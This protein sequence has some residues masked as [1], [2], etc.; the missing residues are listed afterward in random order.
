LHKLLDHR[1]PAQHAEQFAIGT[2]NGPRARRLPQSGGLRIGGCSKQRLLVSK[3]RVLQKY[4]ASVTAIPLVHV[5]RTGAHQDDSFLLEAKGLRATQDASHEL[6]GG[7]Q[8]KT[9]R[10]FG[11]AGW[12]LQPEPAQMR[13]HGFRGSA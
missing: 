13:I 6:I 7:P 3:S 12:I 11:L 2:W 1:R 8:S 5:K 10:I 4:T 9:Q